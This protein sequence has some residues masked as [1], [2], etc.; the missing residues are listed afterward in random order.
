M[1]R[2]LVLELCS[3]LAGIQTVFLIRFL[4]FWLL[5]WTI[6]FHQPLVSAFPDHA[7]LYLLQGLIFIF[8]MSDAA[9][10]AKQLFQRQQL[11]WPAR[12]MEHFILDSITKGV[13]GIKMRKAG[14]M[15]HALLKP[16]NV[17]VYR[18]SP[19]NK[20]QPWSHVRWAMLKT[21]TNLHSIS[22]EWHKL[23]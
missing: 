17:Q 10:V 3:V 7:H 11:Q 4:I 23:T 21:F 15:A 22:I 5:S 20:L 6:L 2:A 12:L 16:A 1:F 14:L 18:K 19:L 13:S 8:K 9:S